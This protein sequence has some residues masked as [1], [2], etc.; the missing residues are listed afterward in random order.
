MFIPDS[1]LTPVFTDIDYLLERPVYI[2]RVVMCICKIAVLDVDQPLTAG[3]L[4]K[5]RISRCRTPCIFRR[6]EIHIV[7]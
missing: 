4:N 3:H 5:V 1:H 7:Q 6:F 2:D